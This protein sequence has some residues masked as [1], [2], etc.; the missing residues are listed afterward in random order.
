[1]VVVHY[2]PDLHRLRA[3]LSEVVDG[4]AGALGV[5][6][7]HELPLRREVQPVVDGREEGPG[8]GDPRHL[9]VGLGP[10]GEPQ[11]P[12][13][14]ADVEHPRHPRAEIGVAEALG[15][16]REVGDRLVVGVA[17]AQ[18]DGVRPAVGPAGLGEVDVGVDQAGGDPEAVEIGDV[19]SGG[20]R[21][22]GARAGAVDLAVAENNDRVAYG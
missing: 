17:G 6:D 21:T 12:G 11:G 15:V 16:A 2:V 10:G 14:A 18:V 8:G 5:G 20:D 9:Q 4:G 3:P 1:M 22:G 7:D 13:V 19:H